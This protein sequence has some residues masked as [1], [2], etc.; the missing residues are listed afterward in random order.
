M[1]KLISCDGSERETIAVG[2]KIIVPRR[3]ERERSSRWEYADAIYEYLRLDGETIVYREAYW[4]VPRK[5]CDE[6]AEAG[7]YYRPQ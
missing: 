6:C 7:L 2:H 1:N 4:L 5:H 3:I